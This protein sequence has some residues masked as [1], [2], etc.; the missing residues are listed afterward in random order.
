MWSD[1]EAVIDLLN[2]QHLVGA[3]LRVIKDDRLDPVTVGIYGDW[4]SGKSSVIQL[5]RQHN[6]SEPDLLAVYFNG[7]RFEGYEDAKAALAS[8]ILE[9]IQEEAEKL[10]GGKLA[11]VRDAVIG[12]VK[13]FWSRID[14][15]RLGKQLL[16]VGAN[17]GIAASAIALGA[18]LMSS[19]RE[20]QD[21]AIRP[22]V[23]SAR[24]T[25]AITRIPE[26]CWLPSCRFSGGCSRGTP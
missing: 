15:L 20:S 6:A 16:T 14:K 19:A 25:S 8:T 13:G 23:L 4:G 3:V 21:A 1:N 22:A 24:F 11:H 18:T 5:L 7:W 2:V 10:S 26:A 12:A 9:Q 17:A